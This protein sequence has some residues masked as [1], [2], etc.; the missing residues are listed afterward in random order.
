MNTEDVIEKVEVSA[1]ELAEEQ[2]GLVLPKE[3]DVR[4]EVIEDTGFDPESEEDKPKIDKLVKKRMDGAEK[5]SKTIGSKVSLRDKLNKRPPA[6]T[7]TVTTTEDKGGKDKDLSSDDVLA[8]VGAQISHPDDIKEL[9]R[10]AKLLDTTVT[11]VL[12]DELVLARI[13][14]MQEKRASANANNTRGGRQ[15]ASQA[16]DAQILERSKNGEVFAKGSPEA[17]QLFFARRGGKR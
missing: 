11:Q 3:E 4:A 1:E 8:L 15:G 10:A 16:S 5:L 9:K 2:T 17:E 6:K 12:Q 7:T 14:D 13:K